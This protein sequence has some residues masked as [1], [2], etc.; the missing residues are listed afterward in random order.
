MEDFNFG[1]KFGK[2]VFSVSNKE[3]SPECRTFLGEYGAL[4][5]ETKTSK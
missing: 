3:F 1:A 4:P 2:Q 5:S